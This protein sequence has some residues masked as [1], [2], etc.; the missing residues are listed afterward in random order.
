[1]TVATKKG[2]SGIHIN[3]ANKGKLHKT[4]GVP[5]DKKLTTAQLEQAK[6]SSNPKTRQR[7]NFALNARKWGK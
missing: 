4:L 5:Q 3:P 2:G 6:N 1:M 7:A